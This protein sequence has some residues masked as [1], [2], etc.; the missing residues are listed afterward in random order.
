MAT[1]EVGEQDGGSLLPATV[2]P[3]AVTAIAAVS[4][5]LT[6]AGSPAGHPLPP[7]AFSCLRGFL[8]PKVLILPVTGCKFQKNW[9]QPS[10]NGGKQ[11]ALPWHPR[12]RGIQFPGP[13]DGVLT[14]SFLASFLSLAY[15]SALV[16]ASWNHL[17]NQLP[18]FRSS[19]Q[20]CSWS[21]R[22]WE[23]HTEKQNLGGMQEL[24]AVASHLLFCS[25]FMCKRMF[26]NMGFLE[27]PSSFLVFRL[28]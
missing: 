9:E 24:G 1:R 2:D 16:S 12:P 26:G 25:A 8:E 23:D 22:N 15:S 11:G 10:T 3:E 13:H 21:N 4:L 27:F 28:A 17:L 18:V 14:H 7:F 19:F 5:T 20:V 6:N